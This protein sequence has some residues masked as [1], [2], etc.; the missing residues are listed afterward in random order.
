M[1]K[2]GQ[3]TRNKFAITKDD[4]EVKQDLTVNACVVEDASNDTNRP[5]NYFPD[6]EKLRTSVAWLL[7]FKDI[8]QEIRKQSK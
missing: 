4:P 7:K 6:W 1:Y 2:T 3:N 5:I 8:L